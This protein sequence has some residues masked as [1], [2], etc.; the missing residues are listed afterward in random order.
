M[1]PAGC[2]APGLGLSLLL[3]TSVPLMERCLMEWV[4]YKL[5]KHSCLGDILLSLISVQE[6]NA[7]MSPGISSAARDAKL[8]PLAVHSSGC[9][10]LGELAGQPAA[11]M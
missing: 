9:P 4:F 7:L 11:N 3:P 10:T 2:P 1:E 6:T 5:F 8:H